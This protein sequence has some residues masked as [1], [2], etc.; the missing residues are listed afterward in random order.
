MPE[1]FKKLTEE[2]KSAIAK[3]FASDEVKQLVE[4]TKA[5]DDSGMFKVIISTEDVDRQGESIKQDGWDLKNYMNNPVVL[6]GHSY[7]DLPI[8]V[9]E[10]VFVDGKT[11]I[12][13]GR[14]AS[15]DANPFAQQVRKLYDAGIVRTTSVGFIAK[16]MEG[17]IITEAELLEFSFVPVPANP[18]A[19]SLSQMKELG[20]DFELFKSK[21]IDLEAIQKIGDDIVTPP[22]EPE[23]PAETPAPEA[24]QKE[25]P[26]KK[27]DAEQ[28]G[29][30]LT[31]MQAA[32]DA[33]IVN[34]SQAIMAIV[35]EEYSEDDTETEAEG[36]KSKSQK[37]GR[38]LSTKNRSLVSKSIEQMELAVA[39][40]KELYEATDPEGDKSR[41]EQQG[42]VDSKQRSNEV[43]SDNDL[44][45][46]L[47]TRQVLRMVNNITSEALAKFNQ[48]S[49]S[50]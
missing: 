43:G 26:A 40:L 16:Q 42:A 14:F 21:G 31:K 50:K 15:A 23:K 17:N 3:A 45:S 48:R 18:N 20:I 19:L 41:S 9:A 34:S 12:A 10:K 38:V 25:V 32:V 13:E 33:A 22:V 27:K 49:S 39:A 4:K 8:G 46:W 29:A 1:L 35:S 24:E 11:L 36:D 7:F 2:I 6:W 47:G 30:E 5:A 44:A 28:I 37:V